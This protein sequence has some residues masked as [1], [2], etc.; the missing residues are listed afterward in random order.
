[1]KERIKSKY[2]NEFS[3]INQLILMYYIANY[4]QA[5]PI[6]N[7]CVANT[8]NKLTYLIDGIKKFSTNLASCTNKFD[9]RCDVNIA[10]VVGTL[11]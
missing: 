5:N 1:M 10:I 7:L 3:L 11:Q 9:N 8:N 6:H 2:N 4:N